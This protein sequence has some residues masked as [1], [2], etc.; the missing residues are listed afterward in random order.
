MYLVLI[1]SKSKVD[2]ALALAREIARQQ[3]KESGAAHWFA[4]Y[5]EQPEEEG[6]K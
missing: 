1:M 2:E 3:L 4:G 6:S 5:N